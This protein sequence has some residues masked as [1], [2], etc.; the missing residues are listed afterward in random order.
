MKKAALLIIAF[1]ALSLAGFG[2]HFNAGAKAGLN[3]IPLEKNDLKGRLFSAGYHVG[4]VGSYK[5]NDWFSVSAEIMLTSQKKTYEKLD[6]ASFL[7]TLAENPL[8]SFTGIDI[9][10]IMDTLGMIKDYINDNV[11]N[12]RTGVVNLTYIKV[13]V[14]ACF[15]YKSLYFSVGP[16]VSFLLSNKGNEE[17]S[18]LI[19]IVETMTGL[20]TIPFYYSIINAMFPGYSE[21]LASK[22]EKDKTIGKIDFGVMAE[23]SYRLGNNV[24]LG[25][26][27]HQGLLNYRKPEIYK[28]DYLS[29]LNFSIGYLF[30]FP[31]NNK[32]I[33]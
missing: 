17:L 33:Y 3:M 24:T 25:V 7:G 5:V 16:Y 18:Q 23:V 15:N 2:Q 8:L 1:C 30:N 28:N 4:A 13:P 11:Y 22:V 20:D 12:T 10:E 29:S 14:L 6:T 26:S 19:P 9:D 27:Y 21:P 31:A 32:S